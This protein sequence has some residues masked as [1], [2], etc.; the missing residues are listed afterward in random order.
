[1]RTNQKSGW[2]RLLTSLSGSEAL[3]Q[4]PQ[5]CATLFRACDLLLFP[6]VGAR[7]CP[8]LP[9]GV[10]L[11]EVSFTHSCSMW[12]RGQFLGCSDIQMVSSQDEV[13]SPPCPY[14]DTG[15]PSFGDDTRVAFLYIQIK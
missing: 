4:R 8:G 5:R 15:W 3:S 12:E 9:G 10:P 1:M 2:W 11:Y 6:P 7:D 13:S 14:E